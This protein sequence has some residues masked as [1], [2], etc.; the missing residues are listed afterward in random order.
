MRWGFC[1]N[2]CGQ[3]LAGGGSSPVQADRE[4][5]WV[6][7]KKPRAWRCPGT[8][9]D[10]TSTC[11]DWVPD[12]HCS[13]VQCWRCDRGLE[14]PPAVATWSSSTPQSGGSDPTQ[15]PLNSSELW[16]TEKKKQWWETR[17]FFFFLKVITDNWTAKRQSE[18][19]NWLSGSC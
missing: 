12:L 14:G 15:F 3:P 13:L 6:S 17:R 5:G 4:P 2:V 1:Q 8:G 18:K 7:S 9:F 16:A 19:L 10:H 11:S